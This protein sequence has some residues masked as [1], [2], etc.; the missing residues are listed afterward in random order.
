MAKTKGSLVLTLFRV[1][2]RLVGAALWVVIVGLFLVFILQLHHPANWDSRWAVV[3]LR[4]VSTPPLAGVASWF[5]WAWPPPSFSFMPFVL[6][7]ILGVGKLLIH[8]GFEAVNRRLSG[9]LEVKGPRKRRCTFLSGE[10]VG[11]LSLRQGEDKAAIAV[12]FQ[13]FEDMVKKTLRMLGVWKQAWTPEGVLACFSGHDAAV[14]A[15]EEI[16]RNLKSFNEAQNKLR[17]ALGVRCGINE[18]FVAITDSTKLEKVVDKAIDVATEMQKQARPNSLLLSARMYALLADKSGFAAADQ[19][20]SGFTVYEW[21]PQAAPVAAAARTQAGVRAAPAAAPAK[22]GVPRPGRYEIV[23][24]LGRGAMGAV[25]KARDPQ[26]GRIVAIKFILLGAGHTQEEVEDYKKRFYREAQ[27]AG[28]MS[29]PG[30]VTIH[31]VAEDD[32]GQPYLVMEFIEGTSLDRLLSPKK[33]APAGEARDLK[34]LVDIAIQVADALDYAHHRSVIHRD[35]KPANILITAEGRAKIADF[36]IA[37]VEGTQMTQAGMLVGTPAY[38]SPEQISG[39]KVD[40]RS[41]IFSLGVVLYWMF[42]GTLPFQGSTVTEVVFK[43]IQAPLPPVHELNPNLPPE[44]AQVI[45]RCLAKKPE[46]RY[47]TAGDLVNDLEALKSRL[48]PRAPLGSPG[49]ARPA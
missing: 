1:I 42:T 21:L 39:G 47:A 38:M 33:G 15:A 24:E 31:D 34:R 23:Q 17:T 32:A 3:T 7:C 20:V 13:A 2:Q 40:T 4:K 25:Y 19:K 11:A 36:G 27:T 14:T 12:T 41:D 29:H 16:L 46:E 35:I 22:P 10:V 18:D 44:I 49:T 28:Q 48:A 37:K 6:L 8:D 26:I 5:D 30:I 45:T 9:A 43:V